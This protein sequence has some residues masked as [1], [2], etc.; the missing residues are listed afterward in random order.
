MYGNF[1]FNLTNF[2]KWVSALALT[3]WPELNL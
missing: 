1:K 3:L 2:N